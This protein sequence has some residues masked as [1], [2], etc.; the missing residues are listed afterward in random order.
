MYIYIY[1]FYTD[2]LGLGYT[3][4]LMRHKEKPQSVGEKN[5]HV[6]INYRF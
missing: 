4:L 2:I 5:P 1:Y 6:F 3:I